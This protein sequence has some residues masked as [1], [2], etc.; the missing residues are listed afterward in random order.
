VE[1]ITS[2]F[3]NKDKEKKTDHGEILKRLTALGYSHD[4][5]ANSIL[6]ILVGSTVELSI[7]MCWMSRLHEVLSNSFLNFKLP[8]LTNTVNLLLG[9]EKDAHIR[10]LF[11]DSKKASELEGFVYESLR[12]SSFLS[13]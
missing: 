2:A 7:G 13:G 1:T 9:C 12:M 4:Q 5:L 11:G 8:A 6:A 3:T 10:T